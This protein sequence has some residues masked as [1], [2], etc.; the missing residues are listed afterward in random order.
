MANYILSYDLNGPFPTHAQMDKHIKTSGA[1]YGRVLETVWYLQS[2]APIKQV[3]EYVNRI[4]STND[5]VLIIEAN[6]AYFRNLLVKNE[7][8][9]KGWEK[10]AA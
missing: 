7:A 9:Q 4:L 5:R 3:Y 8:L 2:A 6:D 10:K 1:V